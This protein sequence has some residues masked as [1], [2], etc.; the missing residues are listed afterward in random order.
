MTAI[1]L[2]FSTK[3]IAPQSLTANITSSKLE[4]LGSN[5]MSLQINWGTNVSNNTG[6]ALNTIGATVTVQ[7]S[8]DGILFIPKVEIPTYTLSTV[9]GFQLILTDTIRERYVNLLITANSVTSGSIEA[10]VSFQ[11]A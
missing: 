4:V 5:T 9:S 8:E 3:I 11:K 6:T 2:P 1:L 7:V 10:D